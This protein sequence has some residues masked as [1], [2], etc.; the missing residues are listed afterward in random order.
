MNFLNIGS[1]PNS[2]SH[3]EREHLLVS[4]MKSYILGSICLSYLNDLLKAIISTDICQLKKIHTMVINT[5]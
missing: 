5:Y 4:I 3:N 1:P 2:S